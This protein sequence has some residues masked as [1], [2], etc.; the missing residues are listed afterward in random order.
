VMT[1]TWAL[2]APPSRA[3]I[4]KVALGLRKTGG[5]LAVEGVVRAHVVE[6]H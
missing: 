1:S 3:R 2:S 6:L 4:L 5:R